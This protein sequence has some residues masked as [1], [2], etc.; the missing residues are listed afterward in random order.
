[1]FAQ[2]TGESLRSV[3]RRAEKSWAE[4]SAAAPEGKLL[5]V[6]HGVLIN[7]LLKYLLP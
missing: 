5:I 1:M 3:S 2:A 7:Y 4:I 6:S